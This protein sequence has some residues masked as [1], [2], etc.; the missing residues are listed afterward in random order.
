MSNYRWLNDISQQFLDRDYLVDGQ[1]V[2]QRV[3]EICAAAEKYLNKPGYGAKFKENF[4][5]GWYSLSTPIWANFGTDRGLP[6]SCFGSYISDTTSSIAHTHAEVMMMTK[7]GGGTSAFFGELRPRGSD[8][9]DNG[10][11][12]GSVHFM[13]MFDSLISV[14]SQGSTRRGNFA[15]YLPVDHKDIMEYLTLRTEGS[16]IRHHRQTRQPRRS[17]L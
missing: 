14:I 7:H 3:D 8:I 10:K 13:R 11:S 5:K 15:A 17:R 16:P 12:D 6:I 4:K 9:K 2:D 1:T